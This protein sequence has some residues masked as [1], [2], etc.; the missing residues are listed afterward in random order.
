MIYAPIRSLGLTRAV[1]S[2]DRMSWCIACLFNS[3]HNCKT[4]PCEKCVFFCAIL[5]RVIDCHLSQSTRQILCIRANLPVLCSTYGTN[6]K[7][8]TVPLFGCFVNRSVWL[9]DY[10]STTH[11]SPDYKHL[12]VERHIG[13]IIVSW[14][15]R[16]QWPMGYTSDLI[17][18]TYSTYILTIITMYC[19]LL[20]PGY[21]CV[22]VV[23]NYLLSDSLIGLHPHRY[24][25]NIRTNVENFS[26]RPFSSGC[27]KINLCLG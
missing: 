17:M 2:V 6:T 16:K 11:K 22:S 21:V 4:K 13:H 18:I 19:E 14:P 5:V 9:N 23:G 25:T 20:R 26:R 15:N 27:N 12:N 7:T 1:A 10:I 24:Q 8:P 3:L